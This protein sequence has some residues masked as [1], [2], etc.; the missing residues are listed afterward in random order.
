MVLINGDKY[1]MKNLTLNEAKE[2]L[3]RAGLIVEQVNRHPLK[4]EHFVKYLEKLLDNY[5]FR[6]REKNSELEPMTYLL[7]TYDVNL[8]RFE[9]SEKGEYDDEITVNILFS[10]ISSDGSVYTIVADGT[11]YDGD[12]IEDFKA[13]LDQVFRVK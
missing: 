7:Y 10:G 13:D 4:S 12:N 8:T 9:I 11:S 2:I 3:E 5:G 1:R 6:E